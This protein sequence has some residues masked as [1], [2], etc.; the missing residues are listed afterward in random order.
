VSSRDVE[1]DGF[2]TM[3]STIEAARRPVE[4]HVLEVAGGIGA[5]GRVHLHI[6][7]NLSY[8]TAVRILLMMDDAKKEPPT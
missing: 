5:G 2:V 3:E 1:S 6:N 7:A 4:I 8:A